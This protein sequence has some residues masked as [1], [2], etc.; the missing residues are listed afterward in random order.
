MVARQGQ[1][2]LSRRFPVEIYSDFRA[3]RQSQRSERLTPGRHTGDQQMLL[4][5]TRDAWGEGC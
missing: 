3:S 2:M 5:G 1:E 4:Y